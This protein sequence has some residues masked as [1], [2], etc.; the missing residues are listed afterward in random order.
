MRGRRPRLARQEVH[1]AAVGKASEAVRSTET[2]GRMDTCRRTRHAPHVVWGRRSQRGTGLRQELPKHRVVARAGACNTDGD[3]VGTGRGRPLRRIPVSVRSLPMRPRS[4]RRQQLQVQRRREASVRL[5]H[6]VTPHACCHSTTHR[7]FMHTL[8]QTL[9]QHQDGTLALTPGLVGTLGSSPLDA[10]A[11][12]VAAP[13]PPP[14]PRD[15]G[16][17]SPEGDVALPPGLSRDGPPCVGTNI[18]LS[19]CMARRTGSAVL[20]RRARGIVTPRGRVGDALL[21]ICVRNAV[22]ATER[23]R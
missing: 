13:P 6:D 1:A 11:V 7:R 19:S 17:M 23:E 22:A 15:S 3:C 5:R 9:R 14:P 12:A 18:Q 16:D 20:R 4:Q 2:V 10:V 21:L 8:T